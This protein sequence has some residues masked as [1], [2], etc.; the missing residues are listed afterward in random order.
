MIVLVGGWS[1]WTGWGSC[2]VTCGGGLMKRQRQ[3]DNPAPSSFGQQCVGND[4]DTDACNGMVC[5]GQ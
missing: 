5:P 1:S 2:S 3:C 4:V